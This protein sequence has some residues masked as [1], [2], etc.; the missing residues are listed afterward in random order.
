MSASRPVI[1]KQ[2]QQ[3]LQRELGHGIDLD[4][5]LSRERYARDVLLVCDAFADTDL[6]ALA[7]QFRAQ[8]PDKPGK[9]ASAEAPGAVLAARTMPP[10]HAPHATEWSRDTSGFGVSRPPPDDSA[11]SL[12]DT[13]P[14]RSPALSVVRR[15]LPRM[16]WL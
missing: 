3:A 2:I 15:W 7:L 12:G 13:P 4:L 11:A 1:A 5:M 9:P 16:R 10:G 6:P 14:A 8:S